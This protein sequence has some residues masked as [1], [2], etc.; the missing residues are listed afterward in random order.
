MITQIS[1]NSKNYYN[2]WHNKWQFR[3]IPITYLL[4]RFTEHMKKGL[5]NLKIS[6]YKLKN[7]A[8]MQDSG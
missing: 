4:V 7:A 1:L 5:K 8:I 2:F 6:F 3:F